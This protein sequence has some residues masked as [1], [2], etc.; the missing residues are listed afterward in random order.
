MIARRRLSA[1]QL[2]KLMGVSQPYLSRRLNGSVAFDLD[3]LERI[4]RSLDIEVMRLL[5]AA[6]EAAAGLNNSSSSPQV[7]TTQHVVR[8][9]P[10]HPAV[11]TRRDRARPTSSIPASRRRPVSA[12]PPSRPVA[13]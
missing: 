12:R 5:T 4:A 11:S 3:D 8:T 1:V 2:A 10:D 7:Q 9:T 13:A 6:N